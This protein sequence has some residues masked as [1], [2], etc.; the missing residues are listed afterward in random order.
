M[1]NGMDLGQAYLVMAKIQTQGM[2]LVQ[3]SYKPLARVHLN[4]IF[5]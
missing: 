5:G 1:V 2:G 3:M 4:E